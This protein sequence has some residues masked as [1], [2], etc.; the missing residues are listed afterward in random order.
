[1]KQY[2]NKGISPP[3]TIDI[4]GQR[5]G[6]L[7][8]IKRV[9]NSASGQTRWLCK[10]DCGNEVVVQRYALSSGNTKSC[11]CYRKEFGRVQHKTHGMRGDRLYAT[12]NMMKQRCTNPHNKAYKYYG[13]KGVTV[14][15]EWA[16]NYEAFREW[17]YANGYDD[18]TPLNKHDCTLDR[19]NPFG[20]YEPSN[21]R[22]TNAK[23]Q[24]NNTR[25]NWKGNIDGYKH[26]VV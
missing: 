8:A 4:T 3:H 15:D 16:N 13:A 14:C 1:M 6:R 19:I 9:E 7:V 23:V 24:A 22:W 20:N 10:C 25:R 2:F 17:A 5:F 26:D 11:G 18:T 12:W 21:C